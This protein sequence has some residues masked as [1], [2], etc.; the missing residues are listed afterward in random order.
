MKKLPWLALLL[1][2]IP[3][4]HAEVCTTLSSGASQ[5][6]ISSA[7]SSCRSGNTVA[8]SAGTYG[9][10]T[11]TVTIPCGVSMTGPNV[12]YS[13][14]PNQI[15]AID[16]SSSNGT[17]WG[18]QTTAKCSASQ[19][20]EY[21]EWNGE[22]PT[23]SGGFLNIV[24]GTTNLTV[25]HNYLHGVSAKA[26]C[27]TGQSQTSNLIAFTG[28][29]STVTNNVTISWNVFGT[30]SLS[31]CSAIMQDNSKSEIDD[32]G[33][34]SGIAIGNNVTN[35][36]IDN[37]IFR[38][39]EQGMKFYEGAGEANPLTV[40]YNDY[41]NIHRIN[42]E[43]QSNSGT[44]APA[45]MAIRYNS[46]ENEFQGTP[47]TWGFSSANGCGHLGSS[48]CITNTDYNVVI[49]YPEP[50]SAYIAGGVEE[51]GT[52]GTT[53]SYNLIQGW[54]A[55]SMMIAVNGEFT[56]NYNTMQ[57]NYNPAAYSTCS[58][59]PNGCTSPSNGS[60]FNVEDGPGYTTTATGNTFAGSSSSVTSAAPTISPA[61]GSFTGSQVVTITNPGTNR[62][63]NT[64][65][66]C[67]TDGSTPKPGSGTA[68]GYY[69][70]GSITVTST[71]TVKCVGMWGASNQPYSYPSGYG[72]V[73]SAVVSATYTVG[74][75][76]TKNGLANGIRPISH[77]GSQTNP[78]NG[79]ANPYLTF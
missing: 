67:T 27:C 64:T 63:A 9:P 17:I 11:S 15:A 65:D 75:N 20:I 70:G 58:E 1:A 56:D 4:A 19:T 66:W 24:P 57:N 7:L 31:D 78:R 68:V 23:N 3:K 62:D 59:T 72:Y 34:C 47:G 8:F 10:I 76:T 46:V 26:P 33:F 41:N 32:G 73:S 50:H 42:F 6:A 22:Q 79:Q 69:N 61:S 53:A 54:W 16:G 71:T 21:L 14:T 43:T 39:L 30:P 5:S 60:F 29:N 48:G 18:F 51:W 38:F 37:N 52:R 12:S 13:Q 35:V 74:G 49:G 36:T 45:N 2:F 40:Q 77:L 25:T 55:N 28:P 44:S